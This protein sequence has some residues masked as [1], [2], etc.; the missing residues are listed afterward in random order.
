MKPL[1]LSAVASGR[2]VDVVTYKDGGRVPVKAA[3]LF[4]SPEDARRCAR[5]LRGELDWASMSPREVFEALKAVPRKVAGP[6]EDAAERTPAC[7][8]TPSGETIVWQANWQDDK[9]VI[10]NWVYFGVG[11]TVFSTREE[12]DA[13]LRELGW[14]LV[15][16]EGGV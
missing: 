10:H 3:L 2:E 8:R 14:L 5:V 11:A 13:R 7:R 6:W 9:Y 16:P 12:V 4:H 1:V 15:E